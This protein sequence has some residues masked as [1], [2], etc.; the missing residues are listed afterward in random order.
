MTRI[1]F[2]LLAVAVPA[3]LFAADD[4]GSVPE[5]WNPMA[6]TVRIRITESDRTQVGSG[7]II[8]SSPGYALVLTCAHIMD[9]A[10]DDALVEVDVFGEDESRIYLGEIVGHHIDSDVGLIT[11]RPMKVLPFAQVD[12][13]SDEIAKGDPVMSIGCNNGARPTSQQISV[14]DVNLYL[15]ADHLICAIAPIHGRSGGGLFDSAGRLIGVC[16]A[17]NRKLDHGL[18]AG[19]GAIYEML[20]RHDLVK[21][22]QAD[23]TISGVRTA[24]QTSSEAP[25]RTAAG[26]K[27]SDIEVE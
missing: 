3:G 14:R 27:P 6:A 22:V 13:S 21:L 24:S 26:S 12:L 10:G 5:Q 9:R 20:Q 7:T 2:A 1:V 15:G 19:R 4:L 25:V 18:Y 23:Q 11:I 8:Q 16:S 17:A